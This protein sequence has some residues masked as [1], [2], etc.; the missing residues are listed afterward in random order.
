MIQ[1]PNLS[2]GDISLGLKC[3]ELILFSPKSDGTDTLG[4]QNIKGK[5]AA[6]CNKLPAGAVGEDL[7]QAKHPKCPLVEMRKGHKIKHATT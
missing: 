7:S 5:R 1:S 3:W 4:L 6:P 2:V